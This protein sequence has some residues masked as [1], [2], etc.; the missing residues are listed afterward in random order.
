VADASRCVLT[1]FPW[2]AK[3]A[4]QDVMALL[5]SQVHKLNGIGGWKLSAAE[6][7]RYFSAA[8]WQVDAARNDLFMASAHLFSVRII[9][10]SIVEEENGAFNLVEEVYDPPIRSHVRATITV[11]RRGMHV[12]S[13]MPL[14]SLADPS[15]VFAPPKFAVDTEEDASVAGS[16]GSRRTVEKRR[17]LAAADLEM[18]EFEGVEEALLLGL[19]APLEFKDADGYSETREASGSSARDEDSDSMLDD[20]DSIDVRRTSSV[21]EPK[22]TRCI[23]AYKRSHPST[24]AHMQTHTRIRKHTIYVYGRIVCVPRLQR[25]GS[26]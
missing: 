12:I 16:T 17:K 1:Q 24:D 5:S 23:N 11:C 18:D 19:A 21:Y 13:T 4:R 10:L 3:R 20:E 2:A 15:S 22:V 9:C 26:L 8:W 7:K 14:K 25:S 6:F